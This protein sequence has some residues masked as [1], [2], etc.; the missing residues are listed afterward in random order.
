M[1]CCVSIAFFSFF[2]VKQLLVDSQLSILALESLRDLGNLRRGNFP[3]SSTV[4][5]HLR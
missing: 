5:A 2:Y 1:Y 4:N 3:H